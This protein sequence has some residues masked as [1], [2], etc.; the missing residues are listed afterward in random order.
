LGAKS[1]HIIYL[2]IVSNQTQNDKP[3]NER[4]TLQSLLL[5][6]NASDFNWADRFAAAFLNGKKLAVKPIPDVSIS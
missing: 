6:Q 5:A 4:T 2:N 3:Q 1:T